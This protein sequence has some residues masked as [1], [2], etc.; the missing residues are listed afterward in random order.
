MS[1]TLIHCLGGQRLEVKFSDGRT[2]QYPAELLRVESP[3]AGS[4]RPDA[5][6]RPKVSAKHATQSAQG[7]VRKSYHTTTHPHMLQNTQSTQCMMYAPITAA[8]LPARLKYDRLC[9]SLSSSLV[10]S[11][12]AGRERKETRG[13]YWCPTSR[14]LCPEVSMLVRCAQGCRWGALRAA[15]S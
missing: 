4:G 9:V 15:L 3:S 14:V 2:F 1:P 5:T 8:P 7:P 11:V 12:I 10:I 6:G 13:H